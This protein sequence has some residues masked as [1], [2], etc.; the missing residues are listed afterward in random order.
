[1]GTSIV[2]ECAGGGG[3]VG[4]RLEGR[5]PHRRSAHRRGRRVWSAWAAWAAWAVVWLIAPG[6]PWARAEPATTSAPTDPPSTTASEAAAPSSGQSSDSAS[7]TEGGAAFDP[8]NPPRYQ[9]VIRPG[10]RLLFVGDQLT[11]QMF[12]T[13]AVATALLCLPPVGD[14]GRPT[15]A[16][17]VRVLNGGRNDATATSAAAWLS[18]LLELARPSVVVLG[19]GLN[20]SRDVAAQPEG[21]PERA[22]AIGAFKSAMS[23]LIDTTLK[24]E[25]VRRVI[26]LGPPAVPM[27]QGDASS[28]TPIGRNAALMELNNAGWALC[29]EKQIGFIDGFTAL[30]LAYQAEAHDGGDPP[31]ALTGELPSDVGH[32]VLAS[33]V[34]RGIGLPAERL[35]RAGW[36]PLSPARM[37]RVRGALALKLSTPSPESAD[38]SRAVFE[39]LTSHDELFFRAWRLAG[40]RPS[41]KSREQMMRATDAAWDKAV[42]AIPR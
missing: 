33:A 15:R 2:R 32:V 25:G 22:G 28:G 41:A 27:T 39:S 7:T 40:R 34:L 5:S 8:L 19:L 36:S 29:R 14:D 20:E 17:P 30:Y 42:D 11:Q 1:M 9:D 37:R 4:R 24:H 21:S 6:S 12:Y 18:E 38:F 26:V 31:L 35:D 23:K 16:D 3:A 10:D 13:R